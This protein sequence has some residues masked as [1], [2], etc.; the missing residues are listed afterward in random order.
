M[1]TEEQRKRNERVANYNGKSETPTQDAVKEKILESLPSKVEDIEKTS[2][3]PKLLTNNAISA[4]LRDKQ[5]VLD[6]ESG[7]LRAVKK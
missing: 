6:S 5:V 7:W 3:Y 1:P 4:L 2:G